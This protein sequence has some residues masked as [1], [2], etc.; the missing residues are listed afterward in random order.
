MKQLQ[1]RCVA[2]S[3]V[4]FRFFTACGQTLGTLLILIQCQDPGALT[5]GYIS[6]LESSPK[7]GTNDHAKKSLIHFYK[8]CVSVLGYLD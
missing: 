1:L 3:F 4:Y 6:L 8:R 7:S 2:P 5:G